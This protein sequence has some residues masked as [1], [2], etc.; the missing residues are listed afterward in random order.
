MLSHIVHHE[1]L[2]LQ[3][4]KI[5]A[6]VAMGPQMVSWDSIKHLRMPGAT[7]AMRTQADTLQATKIVAETH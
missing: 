3:A 6:E 2:T 1:S 5:A 4:A 7:D